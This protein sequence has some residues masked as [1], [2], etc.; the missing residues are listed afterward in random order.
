VKFANLTPTP[1]QCGSAI[2]VG[3]RIVR[4]T[5]PIPSGGQKA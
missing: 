1:E 4:S 2:E 5:M 3:E